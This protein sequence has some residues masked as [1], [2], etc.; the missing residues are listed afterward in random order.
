MNS[1]AAPAITSKRGSGGRAWFTS[2][3]GVVSSEPATLT[4]YAYCRR[5]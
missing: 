4:A 3:L 5:R 1:A 2:A